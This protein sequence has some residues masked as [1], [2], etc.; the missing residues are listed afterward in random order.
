MFVLQWPLENLV[1]D[2]EAVVKTLCRTKRPSLPS[3][4]E[5]LKG[6]GSIWADRAED[7]MNG[8]LFVSTMGSGQTTAKLFI[9]SILKEG[10]QQRFGKIMRVFHCS[11][12]RFLPITARKK[13]QKCFYKNVNK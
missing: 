1:N 13:A 5:Y 4:C 3:R 9:G 2:G 10:F 11:L 6:S 7:R 12:P 8:L